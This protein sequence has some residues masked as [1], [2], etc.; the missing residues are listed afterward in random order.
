MKE[1]DC[2][3]W[4]TETQQVVV[5]AQV[6]RLRPRHGHDGPSQRLAQRISL[7]LV[8]VAADRRQDG[9]VLGVLPLLELQLLELLE[10]LV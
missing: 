10:A 3:T 2:I 8:H 1:C 9:Q 6:E 5:P 4:R 7:A